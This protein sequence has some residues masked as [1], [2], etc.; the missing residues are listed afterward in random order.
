MI[1]GA[2]RKTIHNTI[3]RFEQQQDPKSLPR[4]SRPSILT[5]RACQYLYLQARRHPF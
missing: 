5:T 2:P 4:A 3:K 1:L